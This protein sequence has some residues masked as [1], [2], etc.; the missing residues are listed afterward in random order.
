MNTIEVPRSVL[1]RSV[2]TITASSPPTVLHGLNASNILYAMVAMVVISGT[3]IVIGRRVVL[4]KNPDSSTG[5]LR[6]WLAISLVGGLLVLC[7]GAFTVQGTALRGILFGGLVAAASSAITFYFSSSASADA[8]QTLLSAAA[9]N[10]VPNLV[11]RS[12]ADARAVIAETPLQLNTATPNPEDE[13]LITS[14]APIAGTRVA[15]GTHI[16]V[17]T[18]A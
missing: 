13:K 16:L 14:Q 7:V 15:S 11:G 18:Q 5:I 6:S 8:Q 4:G 17:Q 12:V 1:V 9:S 3:I 2:S 10:E